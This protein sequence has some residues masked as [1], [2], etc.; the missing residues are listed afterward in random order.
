MAELLPDQISGLVVEA[1]LK[2]SSKNKK[3]KT[4]LAQTITSQQSNRKPNETVQDPNLEFVDEIS[5]LTETGELDE[6]ENT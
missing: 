3:K 1:A 6:N 2:T 5:A 4:N